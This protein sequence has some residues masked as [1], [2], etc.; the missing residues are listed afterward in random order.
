[1]NIMTATAQFNKARELKKSGNEFAAARAFL[2]AQQFAMKCRSARRQ[3]VID[4]SHTGATL[5]ANR[6]LENSTDQRERSEAGR[7]I[8]ESGYI[9][10]NQ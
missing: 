8:S 6:V 3:H 4:W 1:M 2:T 5:S 10:R 9:F 7:I